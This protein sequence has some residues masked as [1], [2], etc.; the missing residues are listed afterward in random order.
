[1]PVLPAVLST[2]SPPGLISP[3]FSAC[4]IIVAS[5]A[6]LHLTGPGS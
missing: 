1:M 5:G 3:R 2:T 4:R 6:I